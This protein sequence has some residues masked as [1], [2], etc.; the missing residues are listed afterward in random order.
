MRM[1]GSRLQASRG[2]QHLRLSCTPPVVRQP[3]AH[4]SIVYVHILW[5]YT[6]CV[7]CSVCLLC[8][9]HLKIPNTWYK[10]SIKLKKGGLTNSVILM[11]GALFITIFF[12]A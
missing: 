7:L 3:H 1:Q 11:I 2:R 10:Q 9:D 6:W 4:A 8:F 5:K 12:H